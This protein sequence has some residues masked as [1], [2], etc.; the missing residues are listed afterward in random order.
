MCQLFFFPLFFV[1]LTLYFQNCYIYKIK[2]QNGQTTDQQILQSVFFRNKRKKYHAQYEAMKQVRWIFIYQCWMTKQKQKIKTL[3]SA[4]LI[5]KR[6]TT[7]LLIMCWKNFAR[8]NNRILPRLDYYPR[9]CW[10][11]KTH[12]TTI[13]NSIGSSYPE[14]ALI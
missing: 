9:W 10:I 1:Q 7:P 5:T 12:I 13:F 11:P 8:L 6:K 4:L 2:K 3:L 14:P